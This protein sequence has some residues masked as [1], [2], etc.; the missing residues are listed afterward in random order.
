MHVNSF[1]RSLE[2]K[3]VPRPEGKAKEFIGAR[4][5]LF[6]FM[7]RHPDLPWASMV[8]KSHPFKCGVKYFNAL[9]PSNLVS[10]KKMI[11]GLRV[12]T[13]LFMENFIRELSNPL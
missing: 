5:S 4:E 2:H 12:S 3:E 13:D 8:E 11:Y 7:I 9:S 6:H 10:C 1:D